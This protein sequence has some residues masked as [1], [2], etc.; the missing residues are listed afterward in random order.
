MK[1]FFKYFYLFF[2]TTLFFH[3]LSALEKNNEYLDAYLK[4]ESPQSSPAETPK[5]QV[6]ENKIQMIQKLPE[7]KRSNLISERGSSPLNT[8]LKNKSANKAAQENENPIITVKSSSPVES[9]KNIQTATAANIHIQPLEKKTNEPAN[10]VIKEKLKTK[11]QTR[12][13]NTKKNYK[14][15]KK[16]KNRNLENEKNTKIK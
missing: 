1:I 5:T 10:K 6:I 9:P 7:L 16:K 11:N 15:T 8:S 3:N 12:S 4:N 14:T 2:L 13:Y